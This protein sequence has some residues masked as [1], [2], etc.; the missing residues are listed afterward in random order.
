M[1][2]ILAYKDVEGARC[3]E[4]GNIASRLKEEEMETKAHRRTTWP[5]LLPYL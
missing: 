4:A 3:A 5:P 1:Q 2:V